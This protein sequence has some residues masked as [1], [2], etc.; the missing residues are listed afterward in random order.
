MIFHCPERQIGTTTILCIYAIYQLLNDKTI[1][2]VS[3]NQDAS[4]YHI[5]RILRYLSQLGENY[6]YDKR[7]ISKNNG[8]IIFHTI[9][10]YS[11]R[12]YRCDVLIMDNAILDMS[13]RS[14]QILNGIFESTIPSMNINGK[15]IFLTTG[16]DPIYFRNFTHIT[17][18]SNSVT[19]FK[20]N[21]TFLNK[22]R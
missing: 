8:R 16:C 17:I 3:R 11:A 13:P 21:L 22:K 5:E 19:N 7:K 4:K 1:F 15:L 10:T 6:R 9:N 2:F 20:D 12:G 14:T 18:E